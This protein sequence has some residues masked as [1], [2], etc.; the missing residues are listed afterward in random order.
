MSD[1]KSGDKIEKALKD[2]N[3]SQFGN[4]LICATGYSPNITGLKLITKNVIQMNEVN[5][6]NIKSFFKWIS[7]SVSTTS[8]K[9]DKLNSDEIVLEELPPLPSKINLAK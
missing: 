1:G 4:I 2:F 5:S 7:A 9:I 6:E 8:A 3:K